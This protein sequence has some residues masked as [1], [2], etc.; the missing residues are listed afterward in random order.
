LTNNRN[1]FRK[2]ISK[3]LSGKDS[4]VEAARALAGL[5]WKLAGARPDALPHS[6]FQVTNHMIYWQEWAVKWL[7][8]KKPKVP[9]HAVGS[10][11][12]RV[13]PA[14]QSEWEQ[15]VLR[16]RNTLKA[17]NRCLREAD[18]LSRRG[19]MT[20]MEMLHLIGS[21]TSYHIGQVVSIRLLLAA[22]PP[23]SGGATW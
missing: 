11:P 3:A 13:S 15:T 7:D 1:L 22:W 6:L 21:H 20:R 17:L 18:P 14:S 2:T 8:G 4:H 9:K 5:D 16:F 12:G 10:W 19:K 23:P